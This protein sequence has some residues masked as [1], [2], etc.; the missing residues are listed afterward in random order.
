MKEAE[1]RFNS[2]ATHMNSLQTNIAFASEDCTAVIKKISYGNYTKV[3]Y[4]QIKKPQI[5]IYMLGQKLEMVEQ[6]KYLG[7]TLTSK[8]SLKPTV[9]KCLENI[10]KSS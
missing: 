10:Q 3:F 6:F 1:F 9:Y 5:D 2:L 7:F 4:S 8:L